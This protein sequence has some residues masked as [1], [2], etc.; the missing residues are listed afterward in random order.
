ML[1]QRA[2]PLD[3]PEQRVDLVVLELLEAL[4]D[5]RVLVLLELGG[6]G[7]VL[8]EDAEDVREGPE[9]RPADDEDAAQRD[10][11][12]VAVHARGLEGLLERERRHDQEDRQD[13]DTTISSRVEEP[14]QALLVVVAPGA[15]RRRGS[16]RRERGGGDRRA[17]Y[18][19]RGDRRFG[20]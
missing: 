9:Q 16:S 11:D 14:G 2:L 13:D 19:R 7:H 10:T 5:D 20:E 18:A 6:V 3:L 17:G 15:Q 12:L 1:L 4:L 8:G